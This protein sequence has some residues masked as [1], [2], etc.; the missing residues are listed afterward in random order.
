MHKEKGRPSNSRDPEVVQVVQEMFTCSPKKSIRQAGRESGI[1]FHCVRITM[2]V[3][4]EI[5]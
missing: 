2:R 4:C 5:S 3:S 1:S